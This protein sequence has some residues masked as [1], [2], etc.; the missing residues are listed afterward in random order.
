MADPGGRP[1]WP[2]RAP[3]QTTP[4]QRQPAGPPPHPPT[5]GSAADWPP[6]IR[7]ARRRVNL[8]ARPRTIPLAR[9]PA[10]GSVPITA[11]RSCA[12]NESSRMSI[13][14]SRMAATSNR[15]TTGREPRRWR[16]S[17]S[18]RAASRRILAC[19][20]GPTASA[21]APNRDPERVFTSQKTTVPPKRTTRSSSPCPQRQLRSRTSYPSLQVP[22]RSLVLAGGAEGAALLRPRRAGNDYSSFSG[23]SSTLT[24]LNVTTRTDETNRAGRYMSQTQAS[25][26][27]I[28][29]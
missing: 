19:F 15:S 3:E 21:G 18:Q 16:C 1:R 26:R 9:S 20:A 13:R 4:P 28:S 17:R 8:P 27:E 10:I 11:S 5:C 23:S 29:K 2:G 6:D 14:P 7:P 25:R 22:G 12:Q 24:S